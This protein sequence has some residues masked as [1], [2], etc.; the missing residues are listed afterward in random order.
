MTVTNGKA[1]NDSAK[2]LFRNFFLFLLLILIECPSGSA[3]PQK[4]FTRY[5]FVYF[6]FYNKNLDQLIACVSFSQFFLFMLQKGQDNRTVAIVIPFRQLLHI[7]LSEVLLHFLLIFS[8][9]KSGALYI[10]TNGHRM[11]S[12]EGSD[13]ECQVSK[14]SIVILKIV[15]SFHKTSDELLLLQWKCGK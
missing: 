15:K 10:E 12:Y 11:V 14:T 1:N 4:G 3:I 2:N 13:R 8:R 6:N 7:L 9:L 5:A